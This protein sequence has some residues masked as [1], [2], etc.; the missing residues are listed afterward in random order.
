MQEFR[1]PQV[2]PRLMRRIVGVFFGK[3]KEALCYNY[4]ELYSLFLVQEM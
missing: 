3:G 1:V 4:S 2:T